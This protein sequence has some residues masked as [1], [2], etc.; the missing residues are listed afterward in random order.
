MR[1]ATA[2][3]TKGEGKEST[4]LSKNIVI[5]GGHFALKARDKEAAVWKMWFG[6]ML[7]IVSL[8]RR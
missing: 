8:G 5:S 3:P 6:W 2:E 7:E 1:I 4:C